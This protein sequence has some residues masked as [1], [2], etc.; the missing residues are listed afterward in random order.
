M[1]FKDAL[2]YFKTRQKCREERSV[3]AHT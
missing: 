2:I 1:Y 3:L